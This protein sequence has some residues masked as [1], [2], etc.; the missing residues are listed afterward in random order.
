MNSSLASSPSS[1]RCQFNRAVLV[2]IDERLLR[3]PRQQG[4]IPPSF[5]AGVR[6][7]MIRFENAQGMQSASI[8]AHCDNSDDL[9]AVAVFEQLVCRG[10]GRQLLMYPGSGPKGN[11]FVAFDYGFAFG[12][13]PNWSAATLGTMTAAILPPTDPF[14]GQPYMDGTN[15]LPMVDKLRTL[16]V[17]SCSAH[18]RDSTRPV[19]A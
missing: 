1:W 3:S 2:S 15:L 18:W 6:C 4:R 17:R 11:D 13:S 12:G 5:S 9:H 16:T 10:D 19:G 8:P 7:G 14:A